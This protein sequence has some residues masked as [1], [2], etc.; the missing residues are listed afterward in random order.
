LPGVGLAFLVMVALGGEGRNLPGLLLGA[1]LTAGL[2]LLALQALTRR[3]RLPED[4]AIGAVLSVSYGL[5]IVIL[6]VIQAVTSGRPAGLEGFILGS[7]AGMLLNDALVIGGGGALILIVLGLLRRPL[8]MT[9]FDR[10]HAASVGVDTG[11]MDAALMA[12]VLAVVLIGI[13]VV[14]AILIVA[15]LITPAVTARLWTDRAGSMAAIA[16]GIGGAAGYGGAAMS[17]AVPGLPTGAVIVLLAAAAFAV[18]AVIAPD[19]G[20]L[21]RAGRV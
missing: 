1:A 7:T 18:S 20:L 8:V 16:G 12:L 5:G 13:R 11:R 2:G 6:T 10:A 4:T 17:A 19:K 9:A 21:A 15:L 3:T 14:G